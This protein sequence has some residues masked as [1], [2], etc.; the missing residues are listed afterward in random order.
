M[1]HN[2]IFRGSSY[3]PFLY[4]LCRRQAV[5]RDFYIRLWQ[6]GCFWKNSQAA[7]VLPA[8][9]SFWLWLRK[10]FLTLVFMFR[11]APKGHEGLILK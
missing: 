8:P 5:S 4:V 3:A 1:S 9:S 2:N 6:G 11:G 10:F 7:A